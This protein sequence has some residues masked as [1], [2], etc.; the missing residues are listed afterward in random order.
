MIRAEGPHAF[1]LAEASRRLGVSVAAPYRHFRTK[2]D[3]LVA[4]AAKGYGGLAEGLAAAAGRHEEPEAQLAA[5]AAAYVHF[6]AGNDGMFEAMF[7]TGLDKRRHAALAEAAQAPYAEL[8]RPATALTSD[9]AEAA[10]L[11]LAVS[12]VANGYATVLRE[13]YLEGEVSAVAKRAAAAVSAIVR[14]R[15]ALTL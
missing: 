6:T 15:D 12:V 3:L 13:G 11:A 5:C 8:L 9:P 1:S 7:H 10:E 14:G 2:E 4:V